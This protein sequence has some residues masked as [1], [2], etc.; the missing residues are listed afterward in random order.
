MTERIIQSECKDSHLDEVSKELMRQA[1]Q[2]VTLKGVFHLALSESSLLDDFYARLMCDPNMRAMPWDKMQVWFF[3]D[4]TEDDS[5]QLAVATHSGIPEESVHTKFDDV[6]IDCCL[7]SGVDLVD[8]PAGCFE[9]CT[10]WLVVADS[11]ESHTHARKHELA[12][13]LHIFIVDN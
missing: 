6:D 13:V 11:K 5:I 3:G 4:T 10:S 2:C 1:M 9:K 7:C 8:Y 12:G